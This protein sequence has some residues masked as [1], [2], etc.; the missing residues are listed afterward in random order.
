MLLIIFT[1]IGLVFL[2]IKE[3]LSLNVFEVVRRP[4]LS[5]VK[6]YNLNALL[7]DIFKCKYD[8]Q[9]YRCEGHILALATTKVDEHK[10]DYAQ[11]DAF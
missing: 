1:N 11:D 7:Y 2:R 3:S 6:P 4:H 10:T 5:D 8:G 9:E